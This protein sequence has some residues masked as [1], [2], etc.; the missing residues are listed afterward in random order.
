MHDQL[1]ELGREI[2]RQECLRVPGK[3]S[4]LW[5]PTVAFDVVQN[6]LGTE[7]IVTLKLPGLANAHYFTSG[8]FSRLPSLRFLELDGGNIVGDFKN[9]LS[10]LIWFSWHHCPSNLHANGLCLK[11]LVVLK[12][13]KSDITEDWNGWGPC[14]VNDN[15]KVIYL[16]SCK[17]LRRTPDFSKCMNLKRLVIKDCK[18]LDEIN[19]SV[20]QLGR[21]KYLEISEEPCWTVQAHGGPPNFNN[22]IVLPLLPESIGGLKSLSML[23]VENLCKNIA[24][25]HS[26][27][28]LLDLKHLSL[29]NC[30]LLG[31]LPDSVGELRRLLSLDLSCTNINALPDSIGRLESLIKMDLSCTN[32]VEL[33]YSIG[34]LR[35][36]KFMCLDWTK[37]RELP[38]SIWTLENL[39]E[40]TAKGCQNLEG[41]IPGEIVGLSRLTIL[42]LSQSKVSGVPITIN[43]LSNLRELVLTNCNG[44]QSLPDL[45]TSLTKLELSSSP[46]QAEPKN[47]PESLIMLDLCSSP[48]QAVPNLPCRLSLSSFFPLLSRAF[49]LYCRPYPKLEWLGRLH[50]LQTL[51]LV[52]SDFYLPPTDLSSLSQLRS[53]EIT[54]HVPRSLTRL[55][56]S[57]EEL[58]LEDIKT[59][60]EWPLFSNLGNLA[61]LKLFGCQLREIEF[62]NVLG[63]LENLQRLQVRMCKSLVRLSNLSSLK[64]LRVLSVEY[65][66]QLTEIGS[67]PSSPKLGK[68]QTLRVYY[69]ESLQKWPDI[70]NACQVEAYPREICRRVR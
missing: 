41:E 54:C 32:I 64:E 70:P 30:P 27:G 62:D 45:P 55:P 39:E 50:E 17:R 36:L 29:H 21:L 14:M 20:G 19:S 44:L 28:E 67:E 49:S 57:L 58:C 56:S 47:L 16:T 33:P 34:N 53:L 7:N 13:S 11:N 3:R 4:R 31:K 68:L 23:K 52:L 37:I 25:P 5:C 66:P 40:L 2:V 8:E 51:R 65:C 61:E 60:I 59:P 69:C 22:F 42:N 9:L 43:R 46:L 24:L 38:K 35:Q 10:N 63:Q 26:I 15:L 12:L 1:R 6:N 18:F 48:L